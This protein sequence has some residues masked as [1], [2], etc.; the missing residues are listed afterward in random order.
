[1]TCAHISQRVRGNHEI[2]QGT[3]HRAL[4]LAREH[5]DDVDVL[6]PHEPAAKRISISMNF[7][8]QTSENEREN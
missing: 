2:V 4:D 1:L 5:D 3:H 7:E 6:L 8:N